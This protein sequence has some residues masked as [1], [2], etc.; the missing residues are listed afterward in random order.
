MQ[1]NEK[2]TLISLG[3][4][5]VF[6]AGLAGLA[7]LSLQ[8]TNT[9]IANDDTLAATPPTPAVIPA[10]DPN[11]LK[12]ETLREGTGAAAVSGD[13]ITVHYVGTL[14]DG[15]QFDSSR[16]GGEPFTLILGSGS[17]IKGW[18]QGLNGM[19]VGELR[20]LTID[21]ELGYGANANG[22]IPANSTLVFEVELLSITGK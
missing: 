8:Q 22:D 1:N 9:S 17:V 4:I 2:F 7:V 13:E 16:D 19:K 11:K 10:P 14:T 15:K 20:K 5:L 21:P 18:E 3:L 6:V 12:I